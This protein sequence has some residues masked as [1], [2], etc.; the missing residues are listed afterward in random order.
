MAYVYSYTD[1][2]DGI[3]KYVGIAWG[4]DRTLLQRIKEHENYDGWC[5]GIEWKI[6]YLEEFVDTRTDA[7]YMEA[8]YISLYETHKYYNIKKAGWGVSRYIP[9]RDNWQLFDKDKEEELICLRKEL[10]YQ[11]SFNKHLEAKIENF[12]TEIQGYRAIIHT[13]SCDAPTEDNNKDIY[14]DDT[15][16]TTDWHFIQTENSLYRIGESHKNKSRNNLSSCSDKG[17]SIFTGRN[18]KDSIRA[19]STPVKAILYIGGKKKS[20]RKFDSIKECSLC[21]GIPVNK[22]SDSLN[23]LDKRKYLGFSKYDSYFWSSCNRSSCSAEYTLQ[24]CGITPIK[25]G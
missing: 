14:E 25:R 6:E 22:I 18:R 23:S 3:I 20:V 16:N 13:L 11:K 12:E 5:K 15:D 4:A 9:F 24:F 21:L 2:Q 1:K 7:E 8:H 10:E 19:V 17:R